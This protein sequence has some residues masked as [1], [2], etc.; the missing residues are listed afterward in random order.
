VAYVYDPRGRFIGAL[1]RQRLDLLSLQYASAGSD[2]LT[3]QRTWGSSW[4]GVPHDKPVVDGG[5]PSARHGLAYAL[6]DTIVSACYTTH[7]LF[8]TPLY[9][10]PAISPV[11]SCAA[12][13]DR[14]FGAAVDPYSV[15]W[16]DA[17]YLFRRL[18]SDAN[19]LVALRW[20]RIASARTDEPA[21][22]VGVLPLRPRGSYHYLLS[23][24]LVRVI[25]TTAPRSFPLEAGPDAAIC[26]DPVVVII[27]SNAMGGAFYGSADIAYILAAAVAGVC[28]Q[29]LPT[30]QW[31]PTA[32]AGSVMDPWRRSTRPPLLSAL[33]STGGF[34]T[35]PV[36]HSVPLQPCPP[37][38]YPEGACLYTDGSAT[39]AGARCSLFWPGDPQVDPEGL[40]ATARMRHSLPSHLAP[41]HTELM[42]LSIAAEVLT[43]R[44][45]LSQ[46]IL[47]DGGETTTAH[48]FTDCLASQHLLRG[49]LADPAYY[50]HHPLRVAL[51]YVVSTI[52]GFTLLPLHDDLD[53]PAFSIHLH[54]VRAHAGVSGNTVAHELA[55]DAAT[56]R[57]T[58]DPDDPDDV[59]TRHV[60]VTFFDDTHIISLTLPPAEGSTD[61]VVV[62]NPQVSLPLH[63]AAMHEEHMRKAN[64]A[65][66][67]SFLVHTGETAYQQDATL[68]NHM[69]STVRDPA[70]RM[71]LKCR[72]GQFFSMREACIRHCPG[73]NSTLCPHCV[74]TT[75]PADQPWLFED[76]WHHR[77]DWCA[78]PKLH[79]IRC[80][81]ANSSARLLG[82][83]IR[84][85]TLGGHTLT[86]DADADEKFQQ[87]RPGWRPRQADRN[88]SARLAADPHASSISSGA[89]DTTPSVPSLHGA[90]QPP[91]LVGTISEEDSAS[92]GD[93][94]YD[95]HRIATC[96]TAC[97]A[98][99]NGAPSKVAPSRIGRCR[100]RRIHPTSSKSWASRGA[101]ARGVTTTA[102]PSRFAYSSSCT[103]ASGA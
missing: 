50:V 89:S 2:L 81:R 63:L 9:C 45:P 53:I 59:P 29:P 96:C 83:A 55:I 21:F 43:R 94:N 34:Y 5:K 8:G 92:E 51:A 98:L 27:V 11:V 44:M 36:P 35:V 57:V 82:R 86:V 24:P 1:P 20:A 19:V 3:S 15:L 93:T 10:H 77:S 69:W 80:A 103:L 28:T 71:T 72:T 7:S 38:A 42:G 30:P 13:V 87:F 102:A 16:A 22:G 18:G 31:R 41:I 84:R 100:G 47:A 40:G 48:V 64:S 25:A 73:A 39:R 75:L 46:P 79:A 95:E 97:D 49:Y 74:T 26:A 17:S 67:R 14:P 23:H 88:A 90:R 37:Y 56:G 76:G 65:P 33:S 68:S 99:R 52:H 62:R 54:K 85:G 91:A 101:R 4:G 12:E 32:T 60:N 70:L 61:R 58:H 66:H 6:A 78:H